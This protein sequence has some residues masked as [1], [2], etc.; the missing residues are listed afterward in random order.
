MKLFFG[1]LSI[2]L[3]LSACSSDPAPQK[4]G[5]DQRSYDRQNSAAAKAH[6]QLDR[7]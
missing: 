1:L 6:H 7:E 4:K 2:V 5:F 3:L